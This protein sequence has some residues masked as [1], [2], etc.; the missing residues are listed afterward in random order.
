MTKLDYF[1][2][3]DGFRKVAQ[4]DHGSLKIEADD[5]EFQHPLFVRGKEYLLAQIKRKV[6]TM[7][8]SAVVIC[9]AQE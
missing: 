3:L 5:M 6:N 8:T 4:A 1:E 7:H 2:L 9:S